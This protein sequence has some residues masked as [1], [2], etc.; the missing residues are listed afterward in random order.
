VGWGV[1]DLFRAGQFHDFSQIH[2]SGSLR[3]VFDNIEVMRN[4]EHGQV[5]FLL[6]R[7]Q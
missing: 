5:F 4:K 2:D 7:L 6:K 1:G 3:K